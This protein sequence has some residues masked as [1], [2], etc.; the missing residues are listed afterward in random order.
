MREDDDAGETLAGLA[1]QAVTIAAADLRLDAAR[2]AG[3]LAHGEIAL[4]VR[5]LRES[6]PYLPDA[7]RRADMLAL[8]HRLTTWTALDT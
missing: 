7:A 2:F 6:A 8:L 3:E 4:L 1:E 5:Y